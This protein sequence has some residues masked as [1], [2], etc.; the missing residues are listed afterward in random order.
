M[1]SGGGAKRTFIPPEPLTEE[2]R[3]RADNASR[4]KRG[5]DYSKMMPLVYG[6]ALP[7]LRLGLRNRVSPMVRDAVF[8]SAVLL[9]LCH[10]GYIMTADSS[11]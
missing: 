1:A 7:L 10:A 8:G 4:P 3:L 5:P 9:A 2:Q 11:M 6:P